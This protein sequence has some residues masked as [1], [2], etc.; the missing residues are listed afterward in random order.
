MLTS[1]KEQ[2]QNL[3]FTL[4]SSTVLID[5]KVCGEL[6]NGRHSVILGTTYGVESKSNISRWKEG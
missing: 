5:L 2:M 6:L 1:I 4:T 3:N